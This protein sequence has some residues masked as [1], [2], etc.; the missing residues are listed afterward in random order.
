MTPIV[1]IVVEIRRNVTNAKCYADVAVDD[2][3]HFDVKTR[4]SGSGASD[5]MFRRASHLPS[6]T[7]DP[8]DRRR[9]GVLE[10]VSKSAQRARGTLDA[11]S[12]ELNCIQLNSHQRV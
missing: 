12:T 9:R 4:L 2:V 8:I 11:A 3:P 10:R 6:S 1:A 5:A 7:A